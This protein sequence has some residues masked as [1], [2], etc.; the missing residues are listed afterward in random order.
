MLLLKILLLY[1]IISEAT[2]PCLVVLTER[3]FFRDT[4]DVINGRED[5]M[6]Y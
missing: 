1:I 5:A 6:T 2:I 4:I 3:L